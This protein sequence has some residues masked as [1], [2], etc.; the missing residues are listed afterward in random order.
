MLIWKKKTRKEERK[1]GKLIVKS[2]AFPITSTE[3]G[4]WERAMVQLSPCCPI[5]LSRKLLLVSPHSGWRSG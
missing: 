4:C 1:E 2:T 3:S 5:A